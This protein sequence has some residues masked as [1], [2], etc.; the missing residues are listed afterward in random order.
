MY[1][2]SSIAARAGFPCCRSATI[3]SWT[4]WTSGS[5]SVPRAPPARARRPEPPL[6]IASAVAVGAVVGAAG[7]I[8]CTLGAIAGAIGAVAVAFGAIAGAVAMLGAI[9]APGVFS[10]PGVI[11]GLGVVAG[12]TGRASDRAAGDGAAVWSA[13]AT[14]RPAIVAPATVAQPN[15]IAAMTAG[16]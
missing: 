12:V 9:A 8:A 2:S 11:A 6:G 13:R 16:R 4:S 10:E 14:Q 3:A 5:S 1:C 7:V 15:K